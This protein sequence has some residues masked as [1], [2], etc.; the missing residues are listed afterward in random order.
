MAGYRRNY[1]ARNLRTSL[2]LSKQAGAM[3]GS[4]RGG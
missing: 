3:S 4:I 2:E 1:T